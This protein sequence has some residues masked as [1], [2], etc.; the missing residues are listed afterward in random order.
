MQPSEEA[1]VYDKGVSFQNNGHA[2]PYKFMVSYRSGDM[3]APQLDSKEALAVED[4]IV[5]AVRGQE[6][7]FVGR[8]SGVRVVRLLDGRS[9]QLRREERRC[10]SAP[11]PPS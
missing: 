11:W 3:V 9:G 7:L 10:A 2:D 1:K 4:N 8:T 5:K 6:A